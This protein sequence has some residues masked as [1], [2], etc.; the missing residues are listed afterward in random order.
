M[1]ICGHFKFV[2]PS[3]VPIILVMLILLFLTDVVQLAPQHEV[4]SGTHWSTTNWIFTVFSLIIDYWIDNGICSAFIM[5]II[6]VIIDKS[7]L[8]QNYNKILTKVLYSQLY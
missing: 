4:A 5:I 1:A 2:W 6:Y 7:Q 8:L 3:A